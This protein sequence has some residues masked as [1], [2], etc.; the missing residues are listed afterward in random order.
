ML[1]FLF[2]FEPIH[3]Y[4]KIDNRK[5]TSWGVFYDILEKQLLEI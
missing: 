3:L 5:V 1:Y 2:I 4:N